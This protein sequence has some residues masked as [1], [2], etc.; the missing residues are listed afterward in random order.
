MAENFLYLQQINA[1]FNQMSGIAVTQAVQ[2]D[3]SIAFC[4]HGISASMH[5][6]FFI[7][8]ACTILCIV[9]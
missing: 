9:V 4:N 8:Q 7:P 2:S 5:V 3:R 6:I 1:G